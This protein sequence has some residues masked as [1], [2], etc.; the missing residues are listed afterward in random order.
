MLSFIVDTNI[1]FS[2]L[3]NKESKISQIILNSKNIFTFYTP[4]FTLEE[5]ANHKLKILKITKYSENQYNELFKLF[6]TEF[7]LIDEDLIPNAFY[8]DAFQLCKNIDEDDLFFV[9]FAKYYNSKLWTGD[10]KLIKGLKKQNFNL[11]IE[12]NEIYKLYISKY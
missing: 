7:I 4:K 1:I 9:A 3:L 10:K 11:L 6:M 5:L 8:E 12:T 2:A